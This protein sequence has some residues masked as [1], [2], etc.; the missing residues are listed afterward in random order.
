MAGSVPA[1][2]SNPRGNANQSLIREDGAQ[3]E[4]LFVWVLVKSRFKIAPL[5]GG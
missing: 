1:R 2:A 4:S 3:L 5:G